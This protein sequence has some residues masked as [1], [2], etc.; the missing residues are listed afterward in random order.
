MSGGTAH[1]AG[2][3]APVQYGVVDAVKMIRMEEFGRLHKNPCVRDAFMVGI[4]AGFGVGGVAVV[5]GRTIRKSC[6]YAVAALC[7]GSFAMHEMCKVKLKREKDGMRRAVEVM[8]QKKIAKERER[9]ARRKE[10]EA[11]RERKEE[12]ERVVRERKWWKVL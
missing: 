8:D 9:E 6:S 5:V 4:G 10:R 7:F 3:Q 2:G 1:T 11:E 12:E